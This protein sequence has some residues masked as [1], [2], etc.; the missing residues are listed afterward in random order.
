MLDDAGG[1][2]QVDAVEF[3]L[4]A[5]RHRD[6]V[7][8]NA[9]IFDQ[10][11][12]HHID[13]R[14]GAF[15]RR[16]C[17]IQRDRADAASILRGDSLQPG[18][19]VDRMG[20]RRLPAAMLRQVDRQL[21]HVRRLQLGGGGRDDYVGAHW[22]R[23]KLHHGRGREPAECLPGQRRREI[24]R[25]VHDH[26]WSVQLQQIREA[27]DR[28]AA[29]GAVLVPGEVDAGG[30]RRE[31]RLQLLVV[32][33]DVAVGDV[34][35]AEGLDGGDDHR[36]GIGHVLRSKL[37]PLVDAEHAHGAAELRLQRLTIG[38]A[39]LLERAERLVGDRAR[40]DQPQHNRIAAREIGVARDAD[41]VGGEQCLA[42]AG[43]QAQA[44]IGHTRQPRER[45]VGR[46]IRPRLADRA[47]GGIGSG[48]VAD[49]RLVEEGAERI[50]RAALIVLELH[51]RAFTS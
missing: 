37:P 44:A 48:M 45:A 23:G 42:A 6:P 7:F 31:V 15:A 12:L 22:R 16:L 17:L 21:D 29:A 1:I 49:R 36:G 9:A 28:L 2:E 38:V 24:V 8:G 14:L 39:D 30:Q 10:V 47:C 11:A 50:E 41:G 32:A 51:Q 46:S 19:V 27:S 43:R 26:Q 5:R 35:D 13:R 34:V 20:D 25:L 4:V 3:A 33:I 18:A 40:R